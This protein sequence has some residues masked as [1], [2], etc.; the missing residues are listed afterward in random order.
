MRAARVTLSVFGLIGVVGCAVDT[1]DDGGEVGVETAALCGAGLRYFARNI[2]ARPEGYTHWGPTAVTERRDV[3]GVGVNCPEDGSDCTFDVLKLDRRGTFTLIA[4]DFQPGETNRNGDTGGCVVGEGMFNG[5]AAIASAS[6]EVEVLPRLPGEVHS[7]ITQFS[8]GGTALVM[9]QDADNNQSYYVYR[10][11]RT[12]PAPPYL[13]YT[14]INDRGEISGISGNASEGERA[15]RFDSRSQT[16]TILAPA[17][18]YPHSWGLGIDRQGE[19]LGLSFEFNGVQ[20]LG[21]WDRRS[22]FEVLYT[23]GT[24]E[25]PVRVSPVVWNDRGLIVATDVLSDAM[26]VIPR[27]GLRLDLDELLTN[28]PVPPGAYGYAVNQRGDFLVWS[29]TEETAWLYQRTR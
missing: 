27:P 5:Q 23:Q 19:V 20:S 7:C 18:G 14:D 9:S 25:D 24:P 13:N 22:R 21:T 11:G 3:F 16:M 4:E 8:D 17:A 12:Y 2:T 26:Y 6:G 29:S 28:G 1:V 15:F 10:N